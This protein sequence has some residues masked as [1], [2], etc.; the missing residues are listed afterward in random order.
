MTEEQ[1]KRLE[2]AVIQLRVTT[3]DY[4]VEMEKLAKARLEAKRTQRACE[5]AERAFNELIQDLRKPH[6]L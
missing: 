2:S 5:E 3:R 4:L 6:V 1:K